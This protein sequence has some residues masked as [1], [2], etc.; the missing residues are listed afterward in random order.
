MDWCGEFQAMNPT[1][2]P[3]PPP[4]PVQIKAP[5]PVVTSVSMMQQLDEG[6]VPKVK[7]QKSRNNGSLK[8]IQESP[9][10]ES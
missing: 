6:V 8:D 2:P 9:L 7:F 1:P 4:P 5:E 10:F 3:P